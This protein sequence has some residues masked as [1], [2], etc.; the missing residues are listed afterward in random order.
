MSGSNTLSNP[1]VYL[2][3]ISYDTA[4]LSI[5][6]G[7]SIPKGRIQEALSGLSRY[8]NS[9][10]IL[11]TCN[12]TEVYVVGDD[13]HSPEASIR[14][15]FCDWSG[16]SQE[17]LAP[18]LHVAQGRDAVR[19]LMETASGL[20]SMIVGEWEVQGQVRQAFHIA[21]QAGMVD[22]LLRKLFQ[23]AIRVGRRV[24]DETDISKNALSVS[25]VAVS[26][27]AKAVGDVRN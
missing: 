22:P 23:H 20:R 11:A 12:R 1:Q 3:G 5:R 8:V 6:E 7:L 9:G 10:V 17:Q 18:H 21:E 27:A 25:S 19:H 14:E 15:F 13:R 16:F 4:P 26:L 24:R 2:A